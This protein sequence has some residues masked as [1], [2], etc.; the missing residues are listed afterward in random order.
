MPGISI[1]GVLGYSKGG[2]T[3]EA[4]NLTSE[5]FA[6]D[7]TYDDDVSGTSVTIPGQADYTFDILNKAK[8]E[9]YSGRC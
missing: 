9:Y 1:S 7:T 6:F 3:L 5:A 2:I 8:W 4:R